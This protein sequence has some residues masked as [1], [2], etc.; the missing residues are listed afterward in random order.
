[1]KT[2]YG[3]ELTTT[4]CIFQGKKLKTTLLLFTSLH[5]IQITLTSR[6]SQQELSNF[7]SAGSEEMRQ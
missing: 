1:M 6:M 5:F 2:S 7:G 3:M 4:M